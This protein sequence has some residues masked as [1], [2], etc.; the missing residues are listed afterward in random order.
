LEIDFYIRMQA[1]RRAV[2]ALVVKKPALTE[3]DP[4][5]SSDGPAKEAANATVLNWGEWLV[6]L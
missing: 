6:G 1:K 5:R 2:E 4:E 3:A